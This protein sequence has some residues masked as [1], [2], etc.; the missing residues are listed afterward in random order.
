MRADNDIRSDHAR[1]AAGRDGDAATLDKIGDLIELDFRRLF[2]WIRR[3]MALAA[4]LALVGGA[5]GVAFVL[6]SKPRYTV[7]TDILINPANLQ[8]VANDLYAQPG[9]VDA[10]VLSAGSKLRVLTSGNVLSRVVDELAL[11]RDSEFYDPTPSLLSGLLATPATGPAPDPKLIALQNL[12][13]RV[14]TLSDDKSFVSTLSV[15]AETSEKAIRISQSMVKFFQEELAR[16]ESEGA[17]RAASA[18]EDRLEQLR[19]D[20]QAAEEKVETYKREKQL[21]SSDGQLVNSQ[22]MTQLNSQ[23]VAARSAVIAAQAAYDGLV[24]A[25]NNATSSDPVVSAAIL[26]LRS[27]AGSLTQQLDAQSMKFGPRHPSIV[28][29][30]AELAAVNAQLETEINRAIK[31]AKA[32]LDEAKAALAALGG[33]MDALKGNVFSDNES[34]VALRQ[35]ERDAAAKTAIYESFMARA[36][37]ITEREQIDTTNVQVI[38][39]P[40]PPAGRSWPP[41]TVLVVGICAILGFLFGIMLAVLR[42]L[43]QEMRQPP[44]WPRRP[45]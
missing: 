40:V 45:A 17:N 19:R 14:S 5:L 15:S 20:V 42:G 3:G 16:A 18:L 22:A 43:I 26:A 11:D 28:G 33:S 2:S 34:Q 29:I 30:K 7:G 12:T 35:L 9:Q 41:R 25:G 1:A 32:T 39:T 38:S 44:D 24:A 4:A 37:Q 31:T 10:Q 21:S 27:R 13:K 8:V 36:R 23:I 6:M